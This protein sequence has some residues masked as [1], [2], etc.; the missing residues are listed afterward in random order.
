M[1][2]GSDTGSDSSNISGSGFS[3]QIRGKLEI[4]WIDLQGEREKASVGDTT[5]LVSRLWKICKLAIW[6]QFAITIKRAIHGHAQ[7]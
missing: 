4:N 3:F 7:A 1:N 5:L 6:C 2:S